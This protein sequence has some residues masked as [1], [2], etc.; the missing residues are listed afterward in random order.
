VHPWP[1]SRQSP[2][3][4]SPGRRYR[5]LRGPARLPALHR[6][7]LPYGGGPR[8]R[9]R[10]GTFVS[11]LRSAF[12]ARHVSQTAVAE[13]P[14]SA[15]SWQ[16]TVVSPGGAPPPPGCRGDEPRPAGA[17]PARGPELPG[18]GCRIER[19]ISGAASGPL[20]QSASPVDAPRR[21]RRMHY[22]PGFRGGDNLCDHECVKIVLG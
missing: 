8:F 2:S 17:A 3:P 15:S 14:P 6:G 13:Q 10:F 9:G 5:P 21:A 20:H 4:A 22:P 7:V 12:R 1:A 11:G 19:R 16:G 18:A